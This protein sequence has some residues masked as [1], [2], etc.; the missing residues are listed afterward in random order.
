MSEFL[1]EILRTAFFALENFSAAA[2]GTCIMTIFAVPVV[3]VEPVI[4]AAFAVVDYLGT[5][6]AAV[7]GHPFRA[8]DALRIDAQTQTPSAT[9][10]STQEEPQSIQTPLS[11]KY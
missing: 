8:I 6:D 2:P 10:L 11:A 5:R 9:Q 1:F 7:A 3:N 4:S